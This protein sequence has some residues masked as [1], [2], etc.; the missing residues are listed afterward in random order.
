MKD[1]PTETLIRKWRLHVKS[2]PTEKC[3]K[4][5]HFSTKYADAQY[6]GWAEIRCLMENTSIFGTFRPFYLPFLLNVH[7][8]R[9]LLSPKFH[10]K[11]CRTYCSRWLLVWVDRLTISMPFSFLLCILDKWWRFIDK[12]L[13]NIATSIHSVIANQIIKIKRLLIYRLEL[14]FVIPVRLLWQ[15]VHN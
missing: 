14:F 8:V 15:N 5:M 1:K 9:E 3:I 12:A 4:G 6:T 11:I 7:Y 13:D 2:R 10:S